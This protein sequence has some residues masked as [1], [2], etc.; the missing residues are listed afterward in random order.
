MPECQAF[1]YPA[2]V[3]QQIVIGYTKAAFVQEKSLFLQG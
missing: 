2:A 3:L 1:L